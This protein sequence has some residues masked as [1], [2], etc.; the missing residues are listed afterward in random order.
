VRAIELVPASERSLDLARFA[1]VEDRAD[2]EISRAIQHPYL[3]ALRRGCA[4]RGLEL[5]EIARR[6]G[7]V[8][9][10]FVETSI[11]GN[12]GTRG[13][14]EARPG[15][16][17]ERLHSAKQRQG[18]QAGEE[19]TPNHGDFDIDSREHEIFLNGSQ[20]N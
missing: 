10:R 2:V 17:R 7:V 5:E 16:R 8:P 13:S 20:K 15:L 12:G 3:R 19:Q 14:G 1:I 18:G 6:L 11:N 4:F 9:G